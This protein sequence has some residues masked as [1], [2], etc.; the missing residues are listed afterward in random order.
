MNSDS[1][2]ATPKSVHSWLLPVFIVVLIIGLLVAIAI[3]NYVYSGPGKISVI[4]N[5][6]RQ[7]DGAKAEWAIEHGITNATQL[8][9]ELTSKDLAPYLFGGL[10]RKEIVDPICGELYFIRRMDESSEAKLTR[11]LREHGWH[12]NWKL[13]KGTIIRFGTNGVE[14]YILP[15]QESNPP[16]SLVEVLQIK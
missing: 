14:G 10:T 5:N 15:G 9:R 11:D 3:P 12:S 8:N 2:T 6:L 4:V 16:K 13:P 1:D 7:I